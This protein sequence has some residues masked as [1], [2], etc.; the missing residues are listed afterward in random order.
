MAWKEKKPTGSPSKRWKRRRW[1]IRKSTT[2][3]GMQTFRV[4]GIGGNLSPSSMIKKEFLRPFLW[5][6][7]RS[8]CLIQK[9]SVRHGMDDLHWQGR[10]T[11][12]SENVGKHGQV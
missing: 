12:Q 10:R 1:D 3:Y 11:G 6:N 9:I 5:M 7:C 8:S 4:N 2:D